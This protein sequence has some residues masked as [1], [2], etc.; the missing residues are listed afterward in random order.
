MACRAVCRAGRCNTRQSHSRPCLRRWRRSAQSGCRQR[1]RSRLC[2]AAV[3]PCA[4]RVLVPFAELIAVAVIDLS[5]ADDQVAVAFEMR[6]QRDDV[7][8]DRVAAVDFI[9]VDTGSGAAQSAHQCAARRIA[10]RRGA[11]GV[12]EIHAACGQRVDI[13][14]LRLRVTSQA[15]DPIVQI[16]DR[17]EQDIRP[18]GRHGRSGNEAAC[19]GQDR[20]HCSREVGAHALVLSGGV[21]GVF[22]F[23]AVA[24]RMAGITR[25]RHLAVEYDAQPGTFIVPKRR[26]KGCCWIIGRKWRRRI[27]SA[28]STAYSG[29]ESP[30]RAATAWYN[31]N[32]KH[33]SFSW[34]PRKTLRST[35][36]ERY[37]FRR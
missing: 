3:L 32:G 4:L 8:A 28:Q 17:D 24:P 35:R 23:E 22:E 15:A 12:G 34:L 2:P 16:V 13:R 36:F 1:R 19:Q 37:F 11:I 25:T 5:R 7:F 30:G 10:N 29:G 6:V 18:L 21:E 31:G 20:G 26:P 33:P 27:A 9:A 14:R